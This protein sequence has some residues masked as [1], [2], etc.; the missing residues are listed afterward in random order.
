MP[1]ASR[2][3]VAAALHQAMAAGSVQVVETIK[4]VLGPRFVCRTPGGWPR[5]PGGGTLA[6]SAVGPVSS[7]TPPSMVTLPKTTPPSMVTLPNTT[8]PSMVT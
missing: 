7:T 8:P 2:G 1:L 4:E 5:G 6:H 3:E